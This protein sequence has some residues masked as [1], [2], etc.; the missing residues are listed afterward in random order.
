[1][2]IVDKGVGNR[3]PK[4]VAH[5]GKGDPHAHEELVA[6]A[7]GVEVLVDQE[8]GENDGRP[9]QAHDQEGH[10]QHWLH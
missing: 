9:A 1:M 2:R 6:L 4:E 5:A 3:Q 8:D 7:A 10:Q